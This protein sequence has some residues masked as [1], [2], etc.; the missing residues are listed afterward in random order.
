MASRLL[1]GRGF[2]A[3]LCLYVLSIFLIKGV[4]YWGGIGHDVDQLVL[5]Q[6]AQLGYDNR[7]PPLYTWLVIAAQS[8]LGVGIPAV[9]AVKSATILGLFGFLYLA[10]RRI[11]EDERLAVLAALGPFAMYE[12]GLWLPV[13][14]S[15]TAA[16]AAVC[17]ATFYVVLRL[18]Q[19]GKTLWY[20]VLGCVAGVGLLIKYNYPIFLLSLLA[21]AAFDPGFR[22]RFADRRMGLVA[23]VALGL[24]A[25]H[26]YWMLANAAEF[27]AAAVS[28]FGMGSDEPF[29]L[30]LA[31]GWASGIKAALNMLLPLAL[32]VP[33]FAWRRFRQGPPGD[34]AERRHYRLLGRFLLIA[35]AALFALVALSGATSVRGHYL[36][37][38]V[39]FPLWLVAWWQGLG[40]SPAAL[41]RAALALAILAFVSPAIMTGKFFVYPLIRDYVPYSLPF[42][43]LADQL[44]DA[45]LREGTLYAYDYP[46]TL[47]GNLR[48]YLAGVRI[49]GSGV[50]RNPTPERSRQGQ[51]LLLW[52]VDRKSIGE[53]EMLKRARELFGPP[54]PVSS[55]LLE[56]EL[57]IV[58]GGGRTVRFRYRLYPRGA[59]S[60]H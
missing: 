57:V 29:F 31:Y 25:P 19:S 51:C 18:E 49:T 35:I 37:I 20:V 26:A 28:R 53:R 5:A 27:Q 6:S 33:Y 52:L 4:L 15:H 41:N 36:L 47:S 30:R 39:V 44:R 7:N 11:F 23:L 3:F 22:R 58:G 2:L 10:A 14:Y 8:V 38:L 54:G 32:A 48:P 9:L 40:L 42:G 45:G 16:L 13:K 59:G 56:S 12:I 43:T 1:T 60:C 24:F 34:W 50:P 21:A 46:Y 55:Q 17:A